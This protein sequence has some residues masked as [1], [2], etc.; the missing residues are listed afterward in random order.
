MSLEVILS[1]K[2]LLVVLARG[3][4]AKVLFGFRVLGFHVAVQMLLISETKNAV[5]HLA[6]VREFVLGTNVCVQLTL[7]RKGLGR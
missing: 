1:A 6:L 7:S 3:Y 4:F 5:W 2:A